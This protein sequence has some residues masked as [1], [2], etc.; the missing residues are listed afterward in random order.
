MED[1]KTLAELEAERKLLD[2]QRK[3]LND[4]IK[5]AAG[6]EMKSQFTT[7]FEQCPTVQ[8][9][10]WR[11]YT[12]YWNDGDTCRFHVHNDSECI[13]VNDKSEWDGDDELTAEERKATEIVASILSKYKS[14]DMERM[15]G[16]HVEV[17]VTRDKVEARDY[18]DHN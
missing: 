10:A 9:F 11:Q 16:D 1:V 14:G 13:V 8:S 18:S 6:R 15:F 3:A 2:E 7:V 5:V 12:D 4:K 17:V